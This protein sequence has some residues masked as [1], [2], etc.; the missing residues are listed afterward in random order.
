MDEVKNLTEYLVMS[1]IKHLFSTATVKLLRTLREV[2]N[3]PHRQQQ[4][5]I[6]RFHLTRFELWTTESREPLRSKHI[7]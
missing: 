7:T 6:G 5:D 3:L 2:C 4:A 1:S